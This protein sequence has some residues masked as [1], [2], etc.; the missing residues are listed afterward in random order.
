MDFFVSSQWV[1]RNTEHHVPHVIVSITTPGDKEPPLPTNDKTLGIL[2]LEFYDMDRV[3]QGYN[4]GQEPK[5]FQPAQAKQ[6]LAFVT[7]HPEAEL[8]VVHCD[9]GLSRSPGVSAALAKVL[10]GDDGELFKRHSGLNRRVYRMILDEHYG[11]PT[12]D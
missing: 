7:A 10:N 12:G 6:V 2:R 11:P 4:E 8:V 5:M 1:A 3:V 9:A